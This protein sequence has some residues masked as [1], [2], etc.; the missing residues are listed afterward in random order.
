M[1]FAWLNIVDYFLCL[2]SEFLIAWPP[3][4]LFTHFLPSRDL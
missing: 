2:F 3:L 4:I 1:F